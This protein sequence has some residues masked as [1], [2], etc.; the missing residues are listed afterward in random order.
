MRT[1]KGKWKRTG[2]IRPRRRMREPKRQVGLGECKAEGIGVGARRTGAGKCV[3]VGWGDGGGRGGRG[4]EE[5][6]V[7]VRVRGMGERPS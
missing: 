5:K 1:R 4:G 7:C 6:E 2:G 3:D